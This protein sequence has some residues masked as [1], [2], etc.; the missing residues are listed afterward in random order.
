[1][2][3]FRGPLNRLPPKCGRTTTL[4][5]RFLDVFYPFPGA[6]FSFY[7]CD[8]R[9]IALRIHRRSM[10]CRGCGCVMAHFAQMARP[11]S[12]RAICV[13]SVPFV[14]H[15]CAAPCHSGPYLFRAARHTS[16]ICSCREAHVPTRI[17]PFVPNKCGTRHEQWGTP[18][19]AWCK[20]AGT[21]FLGTCAT[22]HEKNRD[23]CRVARKK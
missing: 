16:L 21:H 19:L 17:V 4:V 5:F 9:R 18:K 10:A 20:K 14:C 22:W 15:L 11:C 3:V 6:Y 1:M 12:D 7:G 2:E 23:V 8:R 13:P